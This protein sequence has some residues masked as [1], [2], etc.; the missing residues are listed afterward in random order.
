M[1]NA[2]ACLLLSSNALDEVGEVG[3]FGVDS[4]V[5]GLGTAVSPR[6]D[7]DQS[8]RVRFEEGAARITLTRVFA[9]CFQ[10]TTIDMSVIS[11]FSN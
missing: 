8:E 10:D 4:R 5:S 9:T 2:R 7:S 6:D 3:D 1:L 11:M